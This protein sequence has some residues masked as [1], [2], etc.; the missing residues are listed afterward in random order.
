MKP[1][2]LI[3]VVAASVLLFVATAAQST[4]VLKVELDD[5]T[6]TSQWVV[7]AVVLDVAPVDLRE[8]GKGLFTDVELLVREVYRGTKVPARYTLRLLG[9]RGADG[10]TMKIPGMPTFKPGEELVLFLEPT[11]MGH[12]PCGLGQGVWRVLTT[13]SGEPWVQQAVSGLHLVTRGR[14]GRLRE[15]PPVLMTDARPLAD[16]VYDIYAIQ[17]APKA[18]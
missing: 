15:V 8:K 14:D 13:P 1:R 7:R 18:P 16:L 10:V 3:G 11:A 2:R 17:S 9:G 12:I 4:T 6:L 5:L